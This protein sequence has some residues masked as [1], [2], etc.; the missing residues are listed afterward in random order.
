MTESPYRPGLPPIPW[1]MRA[2]PIYRQYPVPWF[3]EETAPGHFDFRIVDARKFKPAIE[4]RLCWLCGRPL[5]QYL[6][7]A[8][9]PMCAVNRVN[10]EPPSHRECA[11]FAMQGCPFLTQ[12]LANYRTTGLPEGV[13]DPAGIPITRQPGAGCLWVT[14]R[15]SLFEAPGGQGFLFR[16]GDPVSVTWWSHGRAAT[17]AEVL[18]SIESGYPL[19]LELAEQDGP[20]AIR[21]LEAARDR[22]LTLVPA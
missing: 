9:D 8:I 18:A 20:E 12:Q 15:F 19:L 3:C 11:Q 13:S 1:R 17:R 5:G 4:R 16:L 10:S 2:R 6:A 22:A 7:F 21:E 14:K